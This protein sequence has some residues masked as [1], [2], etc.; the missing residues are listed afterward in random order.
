MEIQAM[1]EYQDRRE[2]RVCKVSRVVLECK[3]PRHFWRQ[4]LVTKERWA[5]QVCQASQE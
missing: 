4:T 3:A 5:L 1:M 2:F